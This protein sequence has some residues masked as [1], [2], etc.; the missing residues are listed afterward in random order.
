M[1]FEGSV[2]EK[3]TKLKGTAHCQKKATEGCAC[4]RGHISFQ[5]VNNKSFG[6][7]FDTR[8]RLQYL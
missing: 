1:K 3:E 4:E 7:D 6:K 8:T 2:L 5:E